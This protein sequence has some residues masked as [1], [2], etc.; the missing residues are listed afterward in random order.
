VRQNPVL[1]ILN[2]N[3]PSNTCEYVIRNDSDVKNKARIIYHN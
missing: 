3:Q 2:F 1:K